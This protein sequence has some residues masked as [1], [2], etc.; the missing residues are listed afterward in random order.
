[1]EM[2]DAK[3][4]LA[5]CHSIYSNLDIEL[6]AQKPSRLRPQY[7]CDL[8]PAMMSLIIFRLRYAKPC[9]Q[10]QRQPASSNQSQLGH[11][12]ESLSMED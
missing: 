5:S 8:I 6:S 12:G 7:F 10:H 3:C 1:M 11:G 9:E 4:K 2:R